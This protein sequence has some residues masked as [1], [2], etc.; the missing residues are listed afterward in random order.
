MGKKLSNNIR[1][2]VGRNH[3][4]ISS[5][6]RG[7]GARKIYRNIDF[8]RT[9]LDV[10]GVVKRIEYDPNRSSYISLVVYKNGEI[11]YVLSTEG[12]TTGDIII[13]TR[14]KE[15]SIKRGNSMPLKQIPVGT[16][17][18]NIEIRP[19]A[20][21]SLA[22][23][24]GTS[25]KLIKIE[26]SKVTLRVKSKREIILPSECLATI[27][28]TSKMEHKNI[29]GGSAGYTRHLGFRPVVRGVAMNPVDHPHGGGEG[30]T[31]GGRVSVTPWA[32]PTKGY[33]TKRKH[34]RK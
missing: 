4:L 16:T 20:G 15:I 12:V 1:K 29:Q 22:R 10:H 19:G 31:S 7:G 9:V 14:S 33:K 30:K 13:S 25:A 24:A 5:Y 8:T 11:A 32:I 18:H 6:H 21:G 28:S 34:L 3:G 2:K 23:A 17:V 26:G 27:G